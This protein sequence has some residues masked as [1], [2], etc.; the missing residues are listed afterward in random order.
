MRT[1]WS[2]EKAL[3]YTDNRL[4]EVARGVTIKSKPI[5][6]IHENSKGQSNLINFVDTP[7]HPSF[8]DEVA[9]AC[10][11]TDG[12]IIVVDSIEGVV[13][14]TEKIIQ[15]ALKNGLSIVLVINKI[16]RLVLE[17]KLPVTDAYFKLLN[18]IDEFNNVI[19]GSPF[20]TETNFVHP[21]QSTVIFASGEFNMCFSLK[22][23]AE[24]YVVTN[25]IN[26]N[27]ANLAKMLWGNF[28]YSTDKFTKKPQFTDQPRT[29]VAFILE[30]LYKLFAYSVSQE[31]IDLIPILAE[32]GVKLTNT[33]Y[34]L[35]VK[36]LIKLIVS[37]A[38]LHT[39]ALIDTLLTTVPNA[40][41][42]N[43]RI[44]DRFFN[45]DRTTAFFDSAKLGNKDG[46]LLVH[47]VK[48][49][50]SEDRKHFYNFGRV[51]SGCI[52]V[53]KSYA[54]LGENYSI[55]SQEDS[56]QLKLQNLW[57]NQT[58]Y[59]VNINKVP[60]GGLCLLGG[61]GDFIYKVSF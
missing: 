61:F 30:P 20:A 37:R 32:Y 17:L 39:E 41:I 60:A 34:K 22:T 7:G 2:D 45:G 11:I 55:V 14:Q 46:P 16:D 40:E 44:I 5:S 27:P 43:K 6:L 57:I 50:H 21:T 28:Y 58:R 38:L 54:V 1:N 31:K 35:D 53:N 24:F 15:E 4:D 9:A 51:L 25:K 18:I 33:E 19:G 48:N 52:E 3:K 8:I 10:R 49:Y 47:T 26:V 29:F 56:I 12:V 13:V 59:K 42:G 36:P 23:F